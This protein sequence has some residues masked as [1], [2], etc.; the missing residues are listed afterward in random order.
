[1]AYKW[2]KENVTVKR[3]ADG[4]CIPNDPSNSDWQA[5]QAWVAAGGVCQPADPP[6][7]AEVDR[8]TRKAAL[9]AEAAADLFIDRLRSATPDQIKTYV[10]NNVTD[11][12]SAKVFIGKLACA[13]AYA[14]NGGTAK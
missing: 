11:F 5:F 1:M 8:A 7:Q 12:A 9:D 6:T 4:A 2:I 13:V 14:L 10:Q 3:L